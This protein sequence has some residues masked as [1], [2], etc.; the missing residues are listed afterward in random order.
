[1]RRGEDLC[2]STQNQEMKDGERK[3]WEP[4]YKT[5]FGGWLR[6]S[7]SL[8]TGSGSHCCNVC[9]YGSQRQAG[10]RGGSMYSR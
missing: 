9:R 5:L 4:S 8:G 2:G 6:L 7:A 1:M 10:G 3:G